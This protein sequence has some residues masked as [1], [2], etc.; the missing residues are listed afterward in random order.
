MGENV[1]VKQPINE[2]IAFE[3]GELSDEKTLKL[4]SKL[5]KSGL[6]WKLQGYYGRT[7]DNL[8]K[9]GYLDRKGKISRKV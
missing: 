1:M 9:T 3:S 7:A 4:F 2:M 8:I 6:V 5:I